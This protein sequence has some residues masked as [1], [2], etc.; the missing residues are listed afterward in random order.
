MSK[1]FNLKEFNKMKK[2]ITSIRKNPL[3]GIYLKDKAYNK[4][5][6]AATMRLEE[7]E[8]HILGNPEIYRIKKVSKIRLFLIKIKSFLFK[9]IMRH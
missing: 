1:D 9:L 6:D 2:S 3:E 4:L 5:R 7:L 8:K